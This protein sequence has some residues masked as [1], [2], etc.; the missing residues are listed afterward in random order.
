MERHD[1]KKKRRDYKKPELRFI[2]LVADQVLSGGCKTSAQAAVMSKA[3]NT[4]GCSGLG[5]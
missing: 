3:C 2:E 1:K 5:S 4:G